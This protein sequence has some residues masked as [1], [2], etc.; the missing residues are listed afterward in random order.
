[1][2]GKPK[3]KEPKFVGFPI[4]MYAFEHE[5]LFVVQK[6]ENAFMLY[7]LLGVQSQN[8]WNWGRLETTVVTLSK[9]LP[10]KN[11]ESDNRKEIRRL[12]QVLHNKSWIK[13]NMNDD[14]LEYDSLLT[15]NMVDLGSPYVMD[16]VCSQNY[17]HTGWLKVT[18]EMFDA[19][20]G[21]A[22]HLRAMV[23]A[24]WRM[25]RNQEN[26]GE[27]RI[28]L[29]EWEKVMGISHATAVKLVKELNDLDLVHKERG[30][31]Y[32]DENGQPKRETNLYTVVSEEERQERN[33]VDKN[34]QY[35][36][37]HQEN[38]D[39][40]AIIA[41]IEGD[42]RCEGTN[43]YKTGKKD[44][45]GNKEYD[46]WKTTTYKETKA[47]LDK[48]FS[49]L[50]EANPKAYD[51]VVFE[52]EKYM[53]KLENSKKEQKLV[54]DLHASNYNNSDLSWYNHYDENDDYAYTKKHNETNHVNIDSVIEKEVKDVSYDFLEFCATLDSLD[55][56]ETA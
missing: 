49:K 22:R 56:P 45:L 42:P 14:S 2:Y 53:Q 31:M 25:F 41:E 30:A 37:E 24:E 28:S 38:I 26:E 32:Q 12:L 19:C 54:M 20:R 6:D 18:Q 4:K 52:G 16:V 44:Y 46:I 10:L 34:E 47:H 13:I 9:Q 7:F 40:N 27:Y 33:E 17:K 11:K 36:S 1:M 55:E 8:Y 3:T 35:S 51:S 39:T 21:N 5:G 29:N 48:R 43:V 23:Y 50:K 15:I